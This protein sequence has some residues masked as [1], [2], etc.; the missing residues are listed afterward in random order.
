[1]SIEADELLSR[2]FQHEL[3]HL[4]GVLLIDRLDELT[5]RQQSIWRRLKRNLAEADI[6]IADEKRVN[7][8]AHAWLKQYFID[9][10]LP[11]I[12]PQAIDPAH[13]FP[14]VS[15][16]GIGVLFSLERKADGEPISEMILVPAAMPRFV[17]V[18]GEE[19]IYIST[20]SLIVRFA[21]QLFPGFRIVGDGV[22]RVLRDSVVIYEG[23]LESLR[24]FKDDVNEVRAGTECGIG[25]K[26]YNDVRPGDQIE[27][28]E[29]VEVQRTLD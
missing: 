24:R 17:R 7:A 3:D 22:F 8:E 2:L 23:E 16:E 21:D 5:E 4:D 10:V 11:L 15:N 20:H 18:P 28:F 6:H 19:A 26:Q 14:F 13:P 25:V 1:M 12:T 9:E 29:R 27:C